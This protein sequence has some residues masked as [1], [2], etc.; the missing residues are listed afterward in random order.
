VIKDFVLQRALQSL[1]FYLRTCHDEATALW[2]EEFLHVPGI[3]NYQGFDAL[4]RPWRA[5]VE[6]LLEAPPVTVS[7]RTM[8]K[9]RGGSP[10]NPHLAAP[11][12]EYVDFVIEPTRIG[13]RLLDCLADVA[14]EVQ[15]DLRRMNQENWNVQKTYEDSRIFGAEAKKYGAEVKKYIY[16][17]VAHDPEGTSYSVFRGGTYDLL[18]RLAT[19]EGLRSALLALST[20]RSGD[21]L[22]RFVRDH[23]EACKKGPVPYGASEDFLLELLEQPP[24]VS[25]EGFLIDPDAICERVLVHREE[26]A[27]RWSR[28]LEEMP[29]D[30]RK[31]RASHLDHGLLPY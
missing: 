22:A 4:K 12:G 30:I 9:P 16:P 26:H 3:S 7:V 25:K 29:E 15:G 10:D 21:W 13:M 17:A 19:R 14:S 18:K 20:H 27:A 24:A 5:V 1:L 11:A 28:L 8:P 6:H 2:L 23:R 31:L